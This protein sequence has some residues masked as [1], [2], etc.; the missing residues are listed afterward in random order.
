MVNKMSCHAD[1][2]PNNCVQHFEGRCKDFSYTEDEANNLANIIRIAGNI[3]L[4][5]IDWL[6]HETTRAYAVST[7]E[8]YIADIKVRIW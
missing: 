1:T 6:T 2:C 5:T 8:K 7:I 4:V 3:Q